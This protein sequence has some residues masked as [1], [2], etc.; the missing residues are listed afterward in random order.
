MTSENRQLVVSAC[1]QVHTGINSKGTPSTRRKKSATCCRLSRVGRV[2]D[3]PV[4]EPGWLRH[5]HAEAGRRRLPPHW[6]CVGCVRRVC[7]ACRVPRARRSGA[8]E[9]MT[10]L[11]RLNRDGVLVA[12]STDQLEAE[13]VPTLPTERKQHDV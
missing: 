4:H 13:L 12:T 2:H 11:P 1:T 10:R 3:H 5:L 9:P 8:Q 7:K 6:R